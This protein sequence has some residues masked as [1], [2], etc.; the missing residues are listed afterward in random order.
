MEPSDEPILCVNCNQTAL[1]L[2]GSAA[3]S[4]P[5]DRFIG[6]SNDF[7]PLHVET[8]K[9]L[10]SILAPA[11]CPSALLSRFRVSVFLYGS[12]GDFQAQ[13]SIFWISDFTS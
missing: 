7:M 13:S 12:P 11:I 4:I 1:V 9:K 5:P 10:T 6:S 8:V 3:S 2:G